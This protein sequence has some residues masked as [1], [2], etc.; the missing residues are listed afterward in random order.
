MQVQGFDTVPPFKY[1]RGNLCM[2]VICITSSYEG[3]RNVMTSAWC[4]PASFYPPIVTAFIG[5]TRFS[6]DLVMKGREFVLNILASDQ[7]E[8]AIYC[9]NHTGRDE[10]KFKELNLKVTKGQIVA[11]PLIAGCAAHIECKVISYHQ[12]G[13]HTLFVGE[14]VAYDEDAGKQPLIRYRGK[15]FTVSEQSLGADEHPAK[16]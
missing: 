6:H 3:R 4:S 13:D 8:T 11:P 2:P 15:F 1:A 14:T 10:D 12:V 7:V 5:L 9:G 16:V